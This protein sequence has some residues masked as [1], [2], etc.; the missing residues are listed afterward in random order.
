MEFFNPMLSM[1]FFNPQ[2]PAEPLGVYD[3]QVPI[4]P[5]LLFK[6]ETVTSTTK[7]LNRFKCYKP[8]K[9]IRTEAYSVTVFYTMPTPDGKKCACRG[10]FKMFCHPILKIIKGSFLGRS[11]CYMSI[12]EEICDLADF[13]G[14]TFYDKEGDVAT[15]ISLKAIR[16]AD[17]SANLTLWWKSAIDNS[18]THE[19]LHREFC[20]GTSSS[21][22]AHYCSEHCKTIDASCCNDLLV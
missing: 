12:Y 16:R 21:K 6:P 4:A 11:G 19:E 14:G 1:E 20:D 8:C 9:R 7:K 17:P 3:P 22:H 15:T 2:A 10:T 5:L 13:I 18:T